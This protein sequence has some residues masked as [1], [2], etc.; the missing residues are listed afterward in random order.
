[1]RFGFSKLIWGTFLLLA[2]ALI[3]FNQVDGFANIGVVS[4]IAA[5]LSLALIV[6]CVAN[7]H[8]ATLPIP[9]AILY[10]IFQA[11][12]GLPYIKI[13][14]LILAAVLASMGLAAL[15]PRRR[16]SCRRK[17]KDRGQTSDR[18]AQA[19]QIHT[20]SGGNDNN[21]YINV[22]FGSTNRSLRAD[23]LETAQL[24][25]NFGA[26]KLSFDQANP[27]PSGAKAVISC[28]FGGIELFVPKHWRVIDNLNCSLGG[29]DIDK[30][31][32]AQA[33]NAPKLTLTGSVSLGGVNV[34]RI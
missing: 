15:L 19:R 17:D 1:M 24:I 14:A 22:N 8:F 4:I 23:C 25:C 7:L 28:S 2:A 12:L 13:W 21:P 29:V 18:N 20:E 11:P 32:T 6:Q 33:E 5:I 31:L 3:V 34:R 9:I 16:L 27:C 30:T 10:I 26:I